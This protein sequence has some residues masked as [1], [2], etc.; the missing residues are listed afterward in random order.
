MRI[1]AGL[2]FLCWTAGAQGIVST[3][4]SFTEVLFALG[5]RERVVAVF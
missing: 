3:A 4:P 5:A 2:L 1:L